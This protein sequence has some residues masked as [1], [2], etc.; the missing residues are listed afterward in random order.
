M[1][2]P[3]ASGETS[4]ASISSAV[5]EV[6]LVYVLPR[7]RN[8]PEGTTAFLLSAA[9]MYVCTSTLFLVYAYY[10]NHVIRWT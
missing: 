10:D 9:S 7:R 3:A 4:V 8:S 2:A 5:S 1:P 6:A